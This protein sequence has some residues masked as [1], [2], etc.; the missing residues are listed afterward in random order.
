MT[1]RDSLGRFIKGCPG[2]KGKRGPLSEE[3]RLKISLAGL[4]KIPWNKGKGEYCIGEKNHFFG[5][6]HSLETKEK[7]SKA[8]IGKTHPN[9]SIKGDKHYNWK[10]GKTEIKHRIRTSMQYIKWRALIFKR[11]NWTCQTCGKRGSEIHAHHILPLNKLIKKVAI[12]NL[13]LNDKFLLIMA[14]PEIFDL[15]NGVTLC[16]SCHKLTFKDKYDTI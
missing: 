3:H 15:N 10:G 2:N 13:S 7:I 9:K 8:G 12:K 16:K 6:H 11:D 5:K 4:G 1:Y 14:L